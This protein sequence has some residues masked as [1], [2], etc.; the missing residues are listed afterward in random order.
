MKP[1]CCKPISLLVLSLCFVG[2]VA[3]AQP[4][5]ALLTLSALEF[6][7]G[8][9]GTVEAR[10]D[11]GREQC[12]VFNIRVAFDPSI[13]RV[14]SVVLGNYLGD[15]MG[16]VFIAENTI[17]NETGIVHVAAAALGELPSTPDDLLFVMNITGLNAG[18]ANVQITNVEV[19]NITG[20]PLAAEALPGDVIVGLTAEVTTGEAQIV[21]DGNV[22][23]R[24]L[25][26]LASLYILDR[27]ENQT[28][29]LLSIHTD[30][31]GGI[32]Y[33]IPFGD[34]TGWIWAS[35][36]VYVQGDTSQIPMRTDIDDE[37][38]SSA[39]LTPSPV[40]A[41]D[42]PRLQISGRVPIR[43]TPDI[44]VRAHRELIG[45]QIVPIISVL[46]SG[47]LRFFQ[48]QVGD[49]TGWILDTRNVTLLDDLSVIGYIEP[50]NTPTR[51]PV[52]TSDAPSVVVSVSSANLRRGPGTEF[53]VVRAVRRGTR[54][55]IVA[56]T[57]NL[58]VPW[59]LVR[60]L[61]SGEVW[62]ASSTV[63]LNGNIRVE[64]I[65]ITRNIPAV[66]A[67][68]TPDL[69]P[70]IISAAAE[71]PCSGFSYIITW[72]DPDANAATLT[73]MNSTNGPTSYNI[74]GGEG[75]FRTDNW[76]CDGPGCRGEWRIAD[77]A[78]N[79]SSSVYT[80]TCN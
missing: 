19:G 43:E 37:S 9:S 55:E 29:P 60:A 14:D 57:P 61:G 39:A 80:N 62:I 30:D 52:P 21:I 76:S 3:F 46:D 2:V 77:A 56:R 27:V 42:L 58:V 15:V 54:L 38:N 34:G 64:D 72:H 67:T 74:S 11:C 35:T 1:H 25:P 71:G 75:T 22:P 17:N 66:P 6:E 78:G 23:V 8:E 53:S 32:Y 26:A 47:R 40:A 12:S 70:R 36:E 51:T 20:Q 16:H 63:T 18:S 69:R 59:Y 33:E 41:P 65:P 28:L 45:N 7:V 24:S 5:A 44:T 50:T 31:H 13:I 4:I 48:V 73:I 79:Q 10:I 68:P 49:T